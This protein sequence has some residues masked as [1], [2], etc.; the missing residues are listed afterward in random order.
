MAIFH[1]LELI[2]LCWLVCNQLVTWLCMQGQTE[3]LIMWISLLFIYFLCNSHFITI[4][5]RTCFVFHSSSS[6]AYSELFSRTA[7]DSPGLDKVRDPI[8]PACP[9]QDSGVREFE[10]QCNQWQPGT[11]PC[12]S[13]WR[14]PWSISWWPPSGGEVLG[15]R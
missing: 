3:V 12:F 9:P 14:K 10:G 11:Q 15:A 4:F 13:S 2:H 8:F 7:H 1:Y 6:V 5:Y